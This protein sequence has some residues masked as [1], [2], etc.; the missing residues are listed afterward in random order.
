MRT[1]AATAMLPV[2]GVEHH[3]MSITEPQSDATARF[4]PQRGCSWVPVFVGLLCGCVAASLLKS[5]SAATLA[6]GGGAIGVLFSRSRKRGFLF[7]LA[8]LMAIAVEVPWSE[9]YRWALLPTERDAELAIRQEIAKRSQPIRL[10]SLRKTNWQESVIDGV[11]RYRLE[12][13]AEWEITKDCD[14]NETRWY[15]WDV[16]VDCRRKGAYFMPMPNEQA[17][18]GDRVRTLGR[19]GFQKT[20]N[21]W[22]SD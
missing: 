12:Y 3:D 4:Q 1:G 13:D 10:V 6:A 15:G 18:K 9:L 16:V 17:K 2:D 21:G 5:P 8:V 7:S 11:K 22:R 20:G 14:W 19:I